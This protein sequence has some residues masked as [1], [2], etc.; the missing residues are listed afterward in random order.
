[1]NGTVTAG[2]GSRHAIGTDPAV[3]TAQADSGITWASPLANQAPSAR[4][5]VNMCHDDHPHTL[6]TPPATTHDNNVYV[7]ARTQA[8]RAATS[9][10]SADKARTDWSATAPNGLCLSCHQFPVESGAT[11]ARPAISAAAYDASAH[12]FTTAA[13]VTW[14]YTLHDGS[15]F[16]RDCTK[17]HSAEATPNATGGGTLGGPHWSPNRFLL[18]GTYNPNGTPGSF[19]CYA[20]HGNG[21]VGTNRSGKDIATQIGKAR[22]HPAN[23]DAVHDSVAEFNGAAWGNQLGGRARHASCMDCHDVHEAKP[24]THNIRSNLAGPASNGAWGAALTTNPAFWGTTAAGN[25]TKKVIVDGV[26]PL[27]TLCFKCHSTYW[28]GTGTPPSSPSL[29]A[30]QTD[31]AR[32]FNPANVGSFAGGT[33]T[34]WQN[35]ET[36]GGYHPV[37]ATAGNNLGAVRL[38]NLVTTP[39]AWSTTARNLMTCVDCHDSD[40]EADPNGPHGSANAFLLRGP[41]S[42]WNN[43]ISAGTSSM[44]ANV[45]CRNCHSAT[46]ANSRFPAHTR[47]DHN[48]PCMKCH[49]AVPHGGPR[50]GMLV[51]PAGASANVGGQIAGWDT[52]APYNNSGTGNRLYLFSYPAN[53]TT[54]WSQGNCGCNGTGH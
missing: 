28:W 38:T 39:I 48:V 42:V 11:P 47:G 22:N 30:P 32:E 49:A 53:N 50:P 25:F 23:A 33:S 18:S 27:A 45:F 43:T 5:C 8:S 41:N 20:C 21:T 14:I 15:T 4:S 52:A 6:T 46:Y 54:N 9:A 29:G 19:Q 10:T 26:D 40:L 24:G 35:L 51:A 2:V 16:D 3:N 44:P 17:C 1:M 31:V 12:Q 36:A 34:N 13:G 37:L 7:D